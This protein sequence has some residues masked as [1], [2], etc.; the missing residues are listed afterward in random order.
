MKEKF[1]LSD[2][3]RGGVSLVLF[4]AVLGLVIWG[5]SQRP[6]PDYVQNPSTAVPTAAP[7]MLAVLSLPTLQPT[8]LPTAVPPN[9]ATP[10]PTST[11][12][13]TATPQPT[14]TPQPTATAVPTT[15]VAGTAQAVA[16]DVVSGQTAVL[17]T[18]A[19]VALGLAGLSVIVSFMGVAGLA[20]ASR[21]TPP[22]AM[23]PPSVTPLSEIPAP[24]RPGLR[25]VYLQPK[26]PRPSQPITVIVQGQHQRETATNTSENPVRT[27]SNAVS[28][29]AEN[30]DQAANSGAEVGEVMVAYRLPSG[31]PPEG[32]EIEMI[33]ALYAQFGSKNKVMEV[34]YGYRNKT[35]HK[36]LYDI[37][38]PG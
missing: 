24:P 10:M 8:T 6:L 28:N 29:A 38:G 32:Q 5:F 33:R 35:I 21:P 26:A 20:W 27:V 4:I 19:N 3:Q 17:I 7:F 30:Q 22:L 34:A 16:V 9:T 37:L 36:Y 18:R 12:A 15:N 31:R 23:Y 1:D 11:P 14:P 25:T 13:P 2:N